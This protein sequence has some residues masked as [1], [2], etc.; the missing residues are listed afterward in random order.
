MLLR[1]ARKCLPAT[2]E[3]WLDNQVFVLQMLDHREDKDLGKSLLLSLT[4]VLLPDS[5]RQDDFVL[6]LSYRTV[7][8]GV[9]FR[10]SNEILFSVGQFAEHL[11][12]N[13][14]KKPM[15]IEDEPFG[16]S[17]SQPITPSVVS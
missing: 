9:S 5:G 15:G 12:S 1:Y 6:P 14:P 17:R 4:G 13:V 7:Q 16:C 11:W 8:F 2:R 10:S 3:C